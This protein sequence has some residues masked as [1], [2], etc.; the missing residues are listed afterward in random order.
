MRTVADT[1]VFWVALNLVLSDYLRPAQKIMDY[2][3]SPENIFRARARELESLGMEK[4]RACR[5]VSPGLL[6]EAARVLAAIERKGWR[7]LTR[8]DEA[9]PALLREIFDPPYV[10]YVAGDPTILAEPAVAVVGARRPTP[11]GRAVAERLARDLAS[12]GLVVVSGLAVGIDSLAHWGALQAGRTVAVLGSGLDEIYPRENK[13]LFRKIAGTGAVATEFPPAARPLAYRFPLR[14]RVIS[15]L[16]LG[17]VVV[18]ATRRSGSLIT[19]RLALEQNRE[20]MAVPGNITSALSSGTNWLIKTGAK[21]VETWED[22]VEELP[23]PLREKLLSSKKEDRDAEPELS[24]EEKKIFD[25][26]KTDALTHIDELVETTDIS[27]SEVL[28]RLLSLELKGLVRQAPGK[29][30][31]RSF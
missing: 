8:D 15:G 25:G 29:C 2:F 5:L 10:L 26:L 20:V 17:V 16:T 11:F 22:V 21:L 28:A 13:D 4:D 18:E 23:T 3:G 31:Q 14:N 7:L 24:P 9:Y 30:F 27:V 1:R 12:R 6:D 19:A